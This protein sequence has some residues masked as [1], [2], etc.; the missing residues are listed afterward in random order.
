[1]VEEDNIDGSKLKLRGSEDLKINVLESGKG[2][3]FRDW[4]E[5]TYP[6]LCSSD[7]PAEYR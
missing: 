7:L 5:S 2:K 3:V 4:G 1:V 6:C